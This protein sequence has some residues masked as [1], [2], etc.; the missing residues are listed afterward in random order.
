MSGV[1]ALNIAKKSLLSH[2][3]AISLTGTNIANVN[4]AG[5]TRQRPIFSTVGTIGTGV[6]QVQLGVEIENIE[7]VYDQFLERQIHKQIH[8]L[9]YSE[10]RKEQLERIEII[11]DETRGEGI[12]DLLNKFLGAWGDLS[13]NPNG[14]AE[15]VA[16]VSVSQSLAYM[17]RSY[18]NDLISLQGDINA[19]I[20]DLI[21]QVNNDLSDI[22]DLNH[23][24]S[25]SETGGGNTNN[26]RDKRTEL[27]KNLAKIIDINYFE[28]AIGSLN[29]F[30]SNGL[31]L[32]EG[33]NC[34]KLDVAANAENSFYYD[35]VFENKPDDMINSYITSGKLA[36][37]LEIRDTTA[38][39]Y[40]DKLNELSATLVQQINEQHRLGYNI[41]HNLGGDFFDATKTE[42]KDIKVSAGIIADVNKIAASE[43]VNGDGN[44]A[45]YI[46]RLKDKLVM[47]SDTSTFNDYYSSLIGRIGQDVASGNRIHDHHSSLINQLVN[48]KESISGVSL[49]EEMLNL[50]RYQMGFNS[51]ARL[52]S[53]VQ[54][55]IDTLLNL[56][57]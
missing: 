56:G 26:L 50:I 29:I 52:C 37:L 23:K 3:T 6:G 11:L 54:E 5:Y 41:G 31:S 25:Q 48:K 12:G 36:G 18:G 55:L 40:L 49:D 30:I 17:F 28:D 33:Q 1:S 20:S 43:T 7:R 32:V 14:Q 51:A 16:L 27:V 2:Q 57:R 34:W 9:G 21:N 24:I 39:N 13:A 44:N 22:A 42:A 15:R 19:K 45:L 53:I 10:A 8:D 4:T 46:C 38:V 47:N 35:I